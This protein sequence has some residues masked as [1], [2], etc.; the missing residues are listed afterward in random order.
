MK[1]YKDQELQVS[2]V[3]RL[4]F[5]ERVFLPWGP[6]HLMPW[7]QKFPDRSHPVR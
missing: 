4:C 5:L 1:N 3:Q 2:F 7:L 6:V